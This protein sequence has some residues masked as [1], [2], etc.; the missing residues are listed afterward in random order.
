MNS[1]ELKSLGIK[2]AIML[3]TSLA[4]AL[5]Q[6]LGATDASAIATDLV[7]LGF[8][9]YGIY[10]HWNQK[11]V[12]ENSVAVTGLGVPTRVGDAVALAPLTGT[13]QVVG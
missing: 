7:D 11:K 9:A 3:L 5:H 12:P 2:V 1:D 13:V 8:L 10:D 6:D 4:T